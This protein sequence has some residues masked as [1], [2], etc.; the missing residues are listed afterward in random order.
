[1]NDVWNLNPIYT[2]FDDAAFTA[3]M[4]S[5]K[6]LVDKIVDQMERIKAVGECY[7][8]WLVLQGKVDAYYHGKD[9]RRI[10]L[11]QQK[12]FRAIK[13]AV[14]KE[15]ENIRK[16]N[17][18]FEDKGVEAESEPEDFEY[19]TTFENSHYCKPNL[20]YYREILEKRSL[21]PEECLMVGNDVG[22]DMVTEQLGM[23]TF[24][25]TDCLINKENKDIAQYPHGSFEELKEYIRECAAE[26]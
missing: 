2:G 12:D 1:M 14:I 3:D 20:D 26:A 11:S 22:E 10:P 24:L 18:F 6:A 21:K 25:L 19:F 16:C 13:N 7:E 5:L 8:N 17:L 4:E 9:R 15:A 23:K